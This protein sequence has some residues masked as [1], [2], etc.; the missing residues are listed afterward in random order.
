MRAGVGEWESGS[1]SE[2][3]GLLEWEI[4]TKMKAD[5]K[6][7]SQNL[8]GGV[9][10]YLWHIMLQNTSWDCSKP[11]PSQK[12]CLN[13]ICLLHNKVQRECVICHVGSGPDS[14]F[15]QKSVK[16]IGYMDKK[17]KDCLWLGS[18]L[19]ND[20]LGGKSISWG[21]HPSLKVGTSWQ[22]KPECSDYSYLD[23]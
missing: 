9:I 5:W 3:S 4:R 1:L 18:S 17:G 20:R 11:C 14:R 6:W 7:A 23:T 12:C 21:C 13:G 8:S 10:L 19:V 16:E 22:D 15:W 2:A